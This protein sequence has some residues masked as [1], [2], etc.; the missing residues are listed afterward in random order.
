MGWVYV[1]M[2]VMCR[3]MHTRALSFI[4][5]NEIK[6]EPQRSN[7][8]LVL[9]AKWIVSNFWLSNTFSTLDTFSSFLSFFLFL[10]LFNL[11]WNCSRIHFCFNT[12]HL[13]NVNFNAASFSTQFFSFL[14]IDF[15]VSYTYIIIGDSL[16]CRQAKFKLH[17]TKP[18]LFDVIY[19]SLMRIIYS[20]K[21]LLNSLLA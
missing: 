7:K 15:A 17:L 21:N 10:V 16:K 19:T 2:F 13:H 8:I 5:A 18:F 1:Y 11:V 14:Q 6:R 12:F 20:W 9:L 3:R 4:H